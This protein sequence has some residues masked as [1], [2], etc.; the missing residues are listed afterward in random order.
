M[1]TVI[2]FPRDSAKSEMA[3]KVKMPVPKIAAIGAGIYKQDIC[4]GLGAVSF[5]ELELLAM[6]G[7]HCG[8]GTV[9]LYEGRSRKDPVDEWGYEFKQI[10]CPNGDYRFAW[11][12]EIG[13][14]RRTCQRATLLLGHSK[15]GYD[16]GLICSE[17]FQLREGQWAW[18]LR[19]VAGMPVRCGEC[20]T[21]DSGGTASVKF[22]GPRPHVRQ[23]APSYEISALSPSGFYRDRPDLFSTLPTV[24]MARK[25]GEHLPVGHFVADR[26][27]MPVV[28]SNRVSVEL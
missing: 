9:K 11:L 6:Q 14:A 19:F 27:Q 18:V 21:R 28:P 3:P 7:E 22:L 24:F 8:Q 13:H 2:Q 17:C 16:R 20:G 4:R 26:R 25:H 12:L 5:P 15:Y 23:I 1:S 10:D